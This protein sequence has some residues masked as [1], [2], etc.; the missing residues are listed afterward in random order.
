MAK[1][2][3]LWD[4]ERI[5]W[6][7]VWRE[8]HG[9]FLLVWTF[10]I[11]LGGLGVIVYRQNRFVPPRFPD[12]SAIGG[13]RTS[14]AETTR[15]EDTSAA[16]TIRVAGTANEQGM[17]H[18]AVFDLR[19]AFD[20]PEAAYM[21]ALLEIRGNSATWTLPRS[22]LPEAFA[23]AAFHDENNDGKL[24]RDQQGLP[25][26]RVAYSNQSDPAGAEPPTFER[27]LIP[28]PM[29]GEV[30]ELELR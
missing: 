23:L 25:Q 28:R 29:P 26:E 18:V 5:G 16:V 20:R 14:E 12:A 3:S 22:S 15:E 21:R 17:I 4:Y 19:E 13:Q 24:N 6:K 27:S 11:L 1:P 2:R 30:I 8:N 9:T 10:V 7:R